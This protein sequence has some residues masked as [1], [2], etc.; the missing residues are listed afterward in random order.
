[1]HYARSIT[2][3]IAAFNR[4]D[5]KRGSLLWLA[6]GIMRNG[7]HHLRKP[8]DRIA[9]RCRNAASIGSQLSLGERLGEKVKIIEALQTPTLTQVEDV[10]I[11]MV[12]ASRR[13]NNPNHRLSHLIQSIIDT[14][15]NPAELELI[16]RIDDDDDLLYFR[17]VQVRYG[18]QL[19]IRFVVGGRKAG[20]LGL[21]SL[22]LETLAHIAPRSNIVF[23]VAD[24]CL[25]MRD[26]WDRDFVRGQE[27][28]SDNIMFI[29]TGRDALLVYEN[30]DTFFK[31]LWDY[32]P[33]AM[34]WAVG[35]QV[36]KT[37]AKIALK[38]EGWNAF[39]HNMLVDSFLETLQFYLWQ[40]TGQRRVT[41][42]SYAV[43]VRLDTVIPEHKQGALWN[44]SRVASECFQDFMSGPTRAV[45]REM[46]AA[47]ASEMQKGKPEGGEH[48][49]A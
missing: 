24:D 33:P 27:L 38:H 7:F 47:L 46:A 1:M 11:S 15:D 30:E 3:R 35:K 42:V 6:R 19:C 17:R 32:G 49:I 22:V 13:I 25:L 18:S 4:R 48:G 45:I 37:T 28:Y 23:G 41:N 43:A 9:Y 16:L 5:L 29:N 31:H 39:G 8:F 14:A 40:K 12:G 21:H 2:R 34:S 36:L 44:K 26:G 10:K 20:F